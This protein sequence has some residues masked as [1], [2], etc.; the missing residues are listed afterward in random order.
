MW[1]VNKNVYIQPEIEQIKI[2]VEKE[3]ADTLNTKAKVFNWESVE[4]GAW[5]S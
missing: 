3:F 2:V 4:E 5:D 1:K